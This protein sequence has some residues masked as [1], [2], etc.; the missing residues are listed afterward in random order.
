MNDFYGANE[1]DAEHRAAVRKIAEQMS[2]CS[3]ESPGRDEHDI[4][5]SHCPGIEQGQRMLLLCNTFPTLRQKV[6]S[7]SKWDPMRLKREMKGWSNAERDAAWFVLA[8]YNWI[9]FGKKF[10]VMDALGRWDQEHR[11]A[12]LRWAQNPW[13]A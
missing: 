10:N 8:V 3:D 11:R 13:W 4:D 2:A 5:L 6:A 9:E 1:L 7:W 12:F